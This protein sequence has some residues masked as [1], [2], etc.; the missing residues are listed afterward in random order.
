[1]CIR[2][3]SE[4]NEETK[5]KFSSYSVPIAVATEYFDEVAKEHKGI[6]LL[7]KYISEEQ[8]FFQFS[9]HS[10]AVLPFLFIAAFL[11]TLKVLQNKKEL[12]RLDQE[13]S[14]KN[15]II[16]QNQETLS[17]IAEIEG[18]ISS[19]GQTQAILDS[20]A[21]G[22]GVWKNVLKDVA[23]FCGS[24]QNIWISNVVRDN[25]NTIKIEGYSLS[26]YSPTD[27]AYSLQNATLNNMMSEALREK[28]A[29]KYNLTFDI[30]SYQ[31]KK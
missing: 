20:A 3:S 4:I 8:K 19:F 9:W 21:S 13:I 24:K 26:K 16:R 2:D 25:S 7:P 30:T 29:F 5:A 23:G 22:T 12:S 10:F 6:N 11:F 17:K 28:N 27:M 15:L 1:M 18:K 31:N 14:Q